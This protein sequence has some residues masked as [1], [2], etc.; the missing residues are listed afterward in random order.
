MVG[1]TCCSEYFSVSNSR[2]AAVVLLARGW[3]VRRVS[4]K[5]CG[6][7]LALGVFEAAAEPAVVFVWCLDWP[8]DMDALCAVPTQ[9]TLQVVWLH[10]LYV[11]AQVQLRS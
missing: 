5:D 9:L 3:G 6:C 4:E 11:P 7:E 1:F 10:S 2:P 8:A